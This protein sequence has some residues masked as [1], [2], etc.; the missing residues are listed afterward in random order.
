V[1]ELALSL[2]ASLCVVTL[3]VSLASMWVALRKAPPESNEN[4]ALKVSKMQIEL[5]DVFDALEKWGKRASVRESRA[6]A[7]EGPSEPDQ[8]ETPT[9]RTGIM[10]QPLQPGSRMIGANRVQHHTAGN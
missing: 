2:I 4:L 10:R 3:A 7:K 5:E 1:S 9:Q 6:R 8:V